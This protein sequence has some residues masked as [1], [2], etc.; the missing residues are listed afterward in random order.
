MGMAIATGMVNKVV[1]V[2]CFDCQHKDVCKFCDE[3][4]KF[5]SDIKTVFPEGDSCPF[6]VTVTCSHKKLVTKRQD[7]ISMNRDVPINTTREYVVEKPA[8]VLEGEPRGIVTPIYNSS[9]SQQTH[10]D[11]GYSSNPIQTTMSETANEDKVSRN[12][13]TREL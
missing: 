4:G 7:G 10:T 9:P 11:T 5:D 2:D 1:G 13:V 8:T 3:V 6:V 12:V